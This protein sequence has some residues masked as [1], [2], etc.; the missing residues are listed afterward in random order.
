MPG[1]APPAVA[2]RRNEGEYYVITRRDPRNT[3]SDCFNNTGTFVASEIR[4]LHRHV[5]DLQMNVGV[6]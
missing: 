6:A 5:P 3:F 4:I 2:T 1:R